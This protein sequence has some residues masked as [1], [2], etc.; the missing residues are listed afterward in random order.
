MF[1]TRIISSFVLF[2]LFISI[3]NAQDAS[4]SFTEKETLLVLNGD[5]LF[6]TKTVLNKKI[7]A[8][9]HALIL[10]GSGPTDR[11]GNNPQMTNN[12]LKK[13]AQALANAGIESTR[14]DKRAIAQSRGAAPE[15]PDSLTIETYMDDAYAWLKKIETENKGVKLFVIGHSEGSLIGLMA[16]I[17][18]QVTGFISL[19][20]TGRTIDLVLKEQLKDMA[21]E[22]REIAYEII[23]SLKAGY[24]VDN[25]P[26]AFFSL[27][28]PGVQP[29]LISW[30]RYNPAEEIKIFQ[31]SVLI[32]QGT[33]D[34]QVKE[35]DAEAL[36]AARPDATYLLIDDMNHVL[37]IS[38]GD[39]DANIG[40]YNDPEL[41]LP[42]NL[43][44]NLVNFIK[45][46]PNR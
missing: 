39:R 43:I 1:K 18:M 37:V 14:Y 6:G 44:E 28:S 17:R 42:A 41:P 20:G 26:P 33:S 11:N 31:G 32:V 15:R 7:R 34:L 36:K 10:S 3:S 35:E 19:A 24:L 2:F 13:V 25:V 30:M 40:T 16:A 45:K 8:K 22:P 4:P 38:A 9:W 23:D 5:T 46:A 21:R 27:F 29:Y 12:S